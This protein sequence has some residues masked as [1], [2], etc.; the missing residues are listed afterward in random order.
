MS[1]NLSFLKLNEECWSDEILPNESVKIALCQL[2][3]M[4]MVVL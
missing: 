2:L 4:V 1:Q 3:S